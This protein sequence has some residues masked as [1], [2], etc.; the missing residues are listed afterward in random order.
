MNYRNPPPTETQ[1]SPLAAAEP[2]QETLPPSE[3]SE[4]LLV[5]TSV[6][7]LL[8]LVRPASGDSLF[9]SGYALV[10]STL[11]TSAF[12]V[13]YWILAA[14]LYPPRI[15]GQQSGA[16]SAM[17]M[18]SNFAQM[19][20]FFALTRFIPRAGSATGRLIGYAYGAC[21]AAS[22]V[23]ACTFVIVAPRVS[24]KFSFFS[25]ELSV[26]VGFVAAVALWGTFSLQ[27][28][29]LTALRR[30]SW[31][32]V[33]NVAF[34]IV[35]LGLLVVFAA[36][37]GGNG[38]FASWNVPVLLAVVPVNLLIYRRL[39]TG[40][41]PRRWSPPSFSISDIARFVAVDYVSSLLLQ[42]YTTALP[43]LIIALLGPAANAGFYVAYIIIAALDLIAV[44][45]TTSLVVEAAHDE[46]RL[47]E[48]ARRVLQRCTLLLVPAVVVIELIAPYLLGV[49]GHGYATE[50]VTLLRMLVIGS[51]L[52]MV[53][54]VYMG[55]LRVERRVGRVVFTQ[56]SISAL[57]IGLT[58][59]LA[60]NWGVESVGIAWLCA[61]G[62]VAVA[63]IPWLAR[64]LHH[65]R[66]GH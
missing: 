26:A 52:R 24:P 13:G 7:S 5:P 60:P 20:M 4:R 43:L 41:H 48:Y 12:G 21:T 28:G 56:L 14:R 65:A 49:F 42:T 58:L 30:A 1:P 62:A 10:I 6:R 8:A 32:P 9:R 55:T 57:V 34:G 17:L 59:L 18:L 3:T 23:F 15:L 35:K 19:N 22:I 33:E 38:I 53:N 25:A 39:L 50:S 61:H 37:L 36:E 47:A 29:V 51:L 46:D 54:I 63:L 31:V 66:G 44:N 64:T 40:H 2:E 45:L 11:A 27:D 16:I